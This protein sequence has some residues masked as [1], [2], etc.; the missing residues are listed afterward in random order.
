LSDRHAKVVEHP[1]ATLE[2]LQAW[3]LAERKVKVSI[4]ASAACGTGYGFSD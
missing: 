2:E 3:L 4:G 1:D